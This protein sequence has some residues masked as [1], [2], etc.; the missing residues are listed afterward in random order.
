M[1]RIVLCML[2]HGKS[3]DARLERNPRDRPSTGT[4]VPT[5]FFS[6]DDYAPGA[7]HIGFTPDRARGVCCGPRK[8]TQD[9]VSGLDRK[10]QGQRV[11]DK[12]ATGFQEVD[13]TVDRGF[14]LNSVT[15]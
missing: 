13:H 6:G 1:N 15:F 8:I 4:L 3:I 14:R 5:G 2:M 9:R 7:H 12:V 11:L 10:R